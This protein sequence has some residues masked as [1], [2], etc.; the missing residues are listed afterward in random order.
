MASGVCQIWAQTQFLCPKICMTLSI[1]LCLLVFCFSICKVK[2]ILF[3]LKES[4]EA[5]TSVEEA[6]YNAVY[7]SKPLSFSLRHTK[8]MLIVTMPIHFE[9]KHSKCRIENNFR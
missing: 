1:L 9:K 6:Q 2:A 5:F 7:V 4:C 3:I 8:Q